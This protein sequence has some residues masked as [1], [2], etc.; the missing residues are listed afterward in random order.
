MCLNGVL[1]PHH[2]GQYGELQIVASDPDSK[3]HCR[4]QVQ[5][6]RE[7]QLDRFQGEDRSGFTILLE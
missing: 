5:K 7:S 4:M 6:I 1:L 3:V 2:F